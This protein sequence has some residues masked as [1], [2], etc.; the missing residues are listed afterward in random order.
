M[1]SF[2]LTNELRL[3]R[4]VLETLQRDA[5]RELGLSLPDV[6]TG[7]DV[8][9]MRQ[10]LSSNPDITPQML[11][12]ALAQPHEKA[13]FAPNVIDLSAP[14]IRSILNQRV[15]EIE[16][17]LA[18]FDPERRFGR[19]CFGTVPGGGLDASSF[20]VEGSD[21][22]AIVIPEG[23][24]HLTNLLTKLVILLQPLTPS[25]GGPVF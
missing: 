15:Q 16:H 1:S 6:D 14:A 2:P 25:V 19:A 20:K 8:E 24:F 9:M 4:K 5:Y 13:E 21:E 7:A 18:G 11:A 12:E 23:F 10:Y 22:Y 17:A 3:S